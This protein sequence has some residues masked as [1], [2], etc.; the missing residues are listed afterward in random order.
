VFRRLDV[1]RATVAEALRAAGGSAPDADPPADPPKV[2]WGEKVELTTDELRIVLRELPKRLDPGSD[3]F[4]WNHDGK[5]HAYVVADRQT[6]L[7][8]HVEAILASSK[9]EGA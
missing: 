4:A 9:R 6:D 3:R 5:G 1:S 7:R 8:S 2:D